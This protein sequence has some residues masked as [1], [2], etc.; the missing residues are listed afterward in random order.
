MVQSL[1]FGLSFLQR[2][3]MK[4]VV[5]MGL[6]SELMKENCVPDDPVSSDSRT[7]MIKY[8]QALAEALQH[9]SASVMPFFS[10]ESM[11]R[12]QEPQHSGRLVSA[13]LPRHT[14]IFY[15][16]YESGFTVYVEIQC[17]SKGLIHRRTNLNFKLLTVTLF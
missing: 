10:A 9:S 11:L 14:Y 3:D 17:V 1:A 5:V 2:M 13:P 15:L 8:C 6:P 4:I 12:L 7:L 16:G